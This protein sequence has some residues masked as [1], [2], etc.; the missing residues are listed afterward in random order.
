MT[1]RSIEA[2]VAAQSSL[3]ELPIAAEHRPGVI[4]Y[5][6]LAAEMARL[7]DGLPLGIDDESGGVFH[8]VEPPERG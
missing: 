4:A 6:T 1:A 8:P 3:L 7:V 5:F 2:I